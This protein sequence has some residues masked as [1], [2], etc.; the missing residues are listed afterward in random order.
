MAWDELT[1]EYAKEIE[2]RFESDVNTMFDPLS[3]ALNKDGNV[4]AYGLLTCRG[5]QLHIYIGSHEGLWAPQRAPQINTT[6]C[7]ES[8][9]PLKNN[10]LAVSGD[11]SMIAFRVGNKV[12]VYRWEA[13]FKFWN[14][15]GDEFAF[16]HYPVA[17]SPDGNELAIGSPED[18]IGGVT[19]VYA[20]PEKKKC[21]RDMSLLRLSLTIDRQTE[22]ITWILANNS[23][24]EVILEQ[25]S[26]PLEYAY[27]TFVEETCVPADDCYVFTFQQEESGHAHPW[28]VCNLHGWGQGCPGNL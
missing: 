17:M 21:P 8:G 1:G 22:D 10:A 5:T 23:T 25:E 3:L 7:I 13:E 14:S 28:T 19:A 11:G 18:L 6:G 20:L 9:R 24:S 2:F 15:L 16:T 12:R 4:L 26:Y 27:A